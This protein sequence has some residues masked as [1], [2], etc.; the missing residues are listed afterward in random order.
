M[1]FYKLICFVF[2]SVLFFTACNSPLKVDDDYNRGYKEGY[3][4]GFSAAHK[5]ESTTTNAED[6]NTESPRV[7]DNSEE[8]QEQQETKDATIPQ[9]VYQTLDYIRKN[10]RA[11]EGYVGG[12]HFGNYENHLPKKTASGNTI[13]YKEYDVNPKVEG[14][15]RGTQRLV[16]GDDGRAWYTN[17][18]YK[19]FIEIK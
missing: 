5:G 1:R 17:N 6:K 15:N 16:I 7:V 19:S 14:K 11:P 3:Q 18:H 4:D 10:N 12:R 8:D 13:D 9:K 2:L